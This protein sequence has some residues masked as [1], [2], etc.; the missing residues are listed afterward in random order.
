MELLNSTLYN[1][2]Q[3]R[4][5][6]VKFPVIEKK[7]F[8]ATH[9]DMLDLDSRSINVLNRNKIHTV[10]GILNNLQILPDMRGCG[11]KTTN[12]IIYK[13]CAYYYATLSN[14][15]KQKYLNK[16]EMLNAND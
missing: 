13:I 6:N 14:T 2:A 4:N 12:R 11:A 5:G 16:I 9:I 7:E 3:K 10:Q 1:I 8:L 15:E